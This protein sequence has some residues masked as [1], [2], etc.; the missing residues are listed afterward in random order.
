M[1]KKK[2]AKSLPDK[3]K[4]TPTGKPKS[5]KGSDKESDKDLVKVFLHN[6]D[7]T[8]QDFVVVLLETVFDKSTDLAEKIM[9]KVHREGQSV[10][11]AYP[12]ETAQAKALVAR[13]LARAANFPL[14]CSV[15]GEEKS[16]T[17]PAQNKH[18][19]PSGW[20]MAGSHPNDYE[21]G[22]DT[23]VRYTG[24]RCAYV[25]HA[26]GEPRG[27]GTLMQQFSPD[28]YLQ[29]RMRMRMWVKTEKVQGRVQPWMRVDGATRGK[30]LGFDNT[31]NRHTEGTTH[32]REYILVLDVPQESTNVAFGVMLCGKGRLWI[33]DV[34]FEVVGEDVATTD[35]PCQR[36]RRRGPKNLNFEDRDA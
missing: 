26:V 34:R 2:T 16:Q 27:F 19:P 3:P 18:T 10:A 1:K 33:D 15:E 32:W 12:L 24:S 6:D 35:C 5:K 25:T 28:D 8:T 4:S 17:A 29:K 31:C 30:M 21:I 14:Q 20:F 23:D 11:G 36:P 22:L 9:F 7:I 13:K